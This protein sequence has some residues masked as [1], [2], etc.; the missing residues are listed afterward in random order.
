MFVARPSLSVCPEGCPPLPAV[1]WITSLTAE[2][3]R[4]LVA[5]GPPQTS[6]THLSV[7]RWPW[8]PQ[9]WGRCPCT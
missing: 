8:A 5:V 9:K 2:R 4:E 3:S 7:P 1:D 6:G